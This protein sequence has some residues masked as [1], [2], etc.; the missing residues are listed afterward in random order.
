[1][2]HPEKI[3][4]KGLTLGFVHWLDV[5]FV[6]HKPVADYSSATGLFV[7]CCLFFIF[8]FYFYCRRHN[9]FFCSRKTAFFYEVRFYYPLSIFA[10]FGYFFFK[11]RPK[12]RQIYLNVYHL[13]PEILLKS[14]SVYKLPPSVFLPI[15]AVFA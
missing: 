13:S 11:Y 2:E 14:V 7:P 1:M 12:P 8:L 15:L 3:G 4:R 10:N 6:Q 5:G 9:S